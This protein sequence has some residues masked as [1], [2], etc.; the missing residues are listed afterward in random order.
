MPIAWK[1]MTEEQ[2]ANHRAVRAKY[3]RDNPARVKLWR[4]TTRQKKSEAYVAGRRRH[5]AS[6]AARELSRDPIAYRAKQA[7]KTKA[8][9]LAHPLEVQAAKARRD[10]RLKENHGTLSGAQWKAILRFYDGKCAYC[11]AEGK[12]TIDHVIPVAKG[13]KTESA[14]IVPACR[15]C[16]S[17]KGTG[18]PLAPVATLLL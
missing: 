17:K 13:G 1:T 18:Q 7:A 14:N 2:K 12:M 3:R 5:Q 11:G 8:W 15:S 6:H 9:K 10:K 16:N 4:Q